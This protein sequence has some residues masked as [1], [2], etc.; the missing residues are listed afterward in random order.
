MNEQKY[1][2]KLTDSS[3]YIRSARERV[4]SQSRE[5]KERILSDQ[6]IWGPLENLKQNPQDCFDN[7]TGS[8]IFKD[9]E[10][11]TDFF[12]KDSHRD[13]DINNFSNRGLNY[14]MAINPLRGTVEEKLDIM[15]EDISDIENA[16]KIEDIPFK[17]KVALLDYL[18]QHSLT[19]Y[20]ALQYPKRFGID[21]SKKHIENIKLAEE[22]AIKSTEAFYKSLL[23]HS[24]DISFIKNFKTILEAIK[25]LNIETSYFKIS[26]LDNPLVVLGNAYAN[27]I[28]YANSDIIIALPA[29]GTQPGIVTKMCMNIAGKSPELHFIPLSTHST[30]KQIGEELSNNQLD[31]LLNKINLTNQNVLVTEDNSNSGKTIVKMTE[32]IKRKNPNNVNVSLAELDPWRVLVKSQASPNLEVTN[33]NHPDFDT[34]VNTVP[35]TRNFLPDRQMRKIFAQKVIFKDLEINKQENKPLT[36]NKYSEILKN[37]DYKKFKSIYKE[38]LKKI[39]D[40]YGYRNPFMVAQEILKNINID[41]YNQVKNTQKEKEILSSIATAMVAYPYIPTELRDSLKAKNS[42]DKYEKEKNSPWLIKGVKELLEKNFEL[43]VKNGGALYIW[44][45]GDHHRQGYESLPGAREQKF[46]Y[47]ISGLKNLIEELRD[48]YKISDDSFNF[49]SMPNKLRLIKEVISAKAKE[50]NSEVFIVEDSVENIIEAKKII[51]NNGINFN[52][53]LV[54]KNNK[55]NSLIECSETIERM[56]DRKNIF[57]YDMDDTLLHEEFRKENQPVNIYLKLKELNLI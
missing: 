40:K 26:E 48:K 38:V 30:K 44:T 21:L 3:E 47:Q 54:E 57:V 29:G 5:T 55:S 12:K 14:F 8:I 36:I 46:R 25:S 15:N 2:K 51:T 23:G 18:K 31:E 6:I 9:G 16:F 53:F 41:I 20:H 11:V 27:S 32:A 22:L 39:G 1:T 4:E 13:G 56:S 37:E 43:I 24:I 19:L 34:A 35:I 28:K 17:E 7:N 52:S 10:N 42:T 45:K 50:M 49:L 33:E